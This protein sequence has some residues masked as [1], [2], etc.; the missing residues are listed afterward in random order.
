MAEQTV[1]QRLTE[2]EGL[3]Q[4]IKDIASRMLAPGEVEL[5]PLDFLAIAVMDRSV[6]LLYGYT[7][8]IRS[9]NFTCAAPIVR[10]HLDSLLRF[11]A[12]WIHKDP[13]ELARLVLRGSKIRDIDDRNGRKMTDTYLIKQLSIQYPWIASVYDETS[14]WVHLS[15]KHILNSTGIANRNE[16]IIN[17]KISRFDRFSEASVIEG[18][19]CM[20]EIT[21]VLCEFLE[22]WNFTKRSKSGDINTT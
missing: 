18:V 1:E 12:S 8:M 3:E 17:H 11:Y 16:G 20:T 21:H 19:E 7:S 10:M 4:K 9:N 6:S 22:G 15:E 13:H 5:F 2:L 14:G